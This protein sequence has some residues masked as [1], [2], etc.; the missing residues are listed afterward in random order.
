MVL[1][2]EQLR[3]RHHGHLQAV[4]H[5]DER[6]QQGHDGLARADVAL[7]QAVH[8]PLARQVAHDLLE[9]PPLIAGEPERQHVESR[10]ADSLV[11]ADGPRLAR[12]GGCAPPQRE[13]E[14]KEEELLE[15]QAPLRGRPAALEVF[16]RGARRGKVRVEQRGPPIDQPVLAA[17]LRRQRIR[18]RGRQELESR[19]HDP[20]HRLRG[21]AAGL[22]VDG[23][24]PARM[25][26][27]VVLGVGRQQLIGG[28]RQLQ[29]A[30]RPAAL[31]PAEQRH[32][33][34]RRQ[35]VGQERL[36]EVHRPNPA[37]SIGDHRLD[38]AKAPA[39]GRAHA[40]REDLADDGREVAGAELRDRL[41][42]ITVLV[43]QGQAQQ[44]VLEHVESRAREVG[45]PARADAPDVLERALQLVGHCTMTAWPAATS[46]S[47]MR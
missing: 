23:H 15:D 16:Q 37:G 17:D 6:G 19:V 3:R 2:R 32:P 9:R 13:S 36:V 43:A 25:N 20:A 24:D 34:S 29:A 40:A 8:G 38:D 47:R 26:P 7:E 10:A 31:H 27:R 35:D 4:L 1:L 11:H 5:R 30:A 12:G 14:L 21:D 22:L 46:I 45:R 28:V 39:P 41:D 18:D 44:Q 42:A 33:A